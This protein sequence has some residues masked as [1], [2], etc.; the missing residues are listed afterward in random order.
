MT[1]EN[2]YYSIACNELHYL[3]WGLKSPFYNSIAAQAQQVA[4]KMLKSV[5]ELV[6]VNIE[7]LMTSHN[8]RGLYDVIHRV[9][10]SFVFDRNRLS[11]LKDY[12][13]DARYPGDNFISVTQEECADAVHIMYDVVKIVNEWRGK[14]E[15]PVEEVIDKTFMIGNADGPSSVNSF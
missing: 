7:K 8:L 10:P 15:Y 3:E 9:E 5:A 1:I 6:C 2:N 4:E 13:Y 11:T 12:Y 14:H